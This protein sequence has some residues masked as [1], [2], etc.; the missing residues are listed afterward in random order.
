MK[1]LDTYET[2]SKIFKLVTTTDQNYYILYVHENSWQSNKMD[3]I[4]LS[5]LELKNLA[6]FIYDFI[7]QNE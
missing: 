2:W 4:H 1:Y 7:S 6:D 5:P 3:V